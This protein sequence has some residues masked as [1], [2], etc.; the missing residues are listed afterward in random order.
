[1]FDYYNEDHA[2]KTEGW[3]VIESI[4]D[5][6]IIFQGNLDGLTVDSYLMPFVQRFHHLGLNI[7]LDGKDIATTEC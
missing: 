7:T 5:N 3:L 6:R 2:T 4:Q 1:M